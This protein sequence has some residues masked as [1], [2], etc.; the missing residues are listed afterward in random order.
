VG[1]FDGTT[2]T[3]TEPIT[4]WDDQAPHTVAPVEPIPCPEPDGGW[5]GF[6][7]DHPFPGS[8]VGAGAPSGDVQALVAGEPDFA[9]LWMGGAVRTDTGW[10][11]SV[12]VPVVAFTGDLERHEADIRTIYTGPLCVTSARFDAAELTAAANAITQDGDRMAAAG[13]TFLGGGAT[14]G[15][16]VVSV[17]VLLADQETVA[18]FT[19]Q[20]PAGMIEVWGWLQPVEPS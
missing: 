7:A 20:H 8:V 10:D 2:L 14:Q 12:Q 4:V 5:G 16:N 13:I 18:W 3:P 1:D 19:S 9:G 6:G 17:H 15:R 11:T